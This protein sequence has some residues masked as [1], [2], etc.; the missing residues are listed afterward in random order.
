MKKLIRA[1]VKPGAGAF[2]ALGE[3]LTGIY[4]AAIEPG[5]RW[6]ESESRVKQICGAGW[7]AFTG[8]VLPVSLYKVV[9]GA[10]FAHNVFYAWM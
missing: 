6:L 4:L 1:L 5:R 10:V 3:M 2:D 9:I 7:C 8:Y